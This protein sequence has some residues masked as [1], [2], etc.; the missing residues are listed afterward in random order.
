MKHAKIGI[1][2]KHVKDHMLN[3][4]LGNN[5]YFGSPF[6]GVTWTI[7]SM[8]KKQKKRNG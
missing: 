2:G 5:F 8:G 1:I 3:V 6:F 7:S 4:I